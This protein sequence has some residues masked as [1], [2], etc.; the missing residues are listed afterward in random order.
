M[1][2]TLPLGDL[3]VFVVFTTW[4]CYCFP[5]VVHLATL[6]FSSCSPLGEVNAPAMPFSLPFGE[7]EV[8]L[9]FAN[10]QVVLGR[11]V[12]HLAECSGVAPRVLDA[13]VETA[14][15]H[16]LRGQRAADHDRQHRSDAV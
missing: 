12:R 9:V 7:V 2:F 10:W 3:E 8:L 13:E 11:C 4:R 1:P 6:R 5:R 16:Q 15:H 14:T